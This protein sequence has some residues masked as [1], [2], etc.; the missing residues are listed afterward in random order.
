M[1]VL[2]LTYYFPPDLCAGS[3][4]AKSLVDA[5]VAHFDNVTVD[6]VTTEP[7]RYQSHQPDSAE[8]ASKSYTVTRAPLPTQRYGMLGQVRSFG[9]YAWFANRSLPSEEYDLVVATSSRLMTA[10]LGAFIARR[11]KV[12]LYL[13]IRDIFVETIDDV[14]R[15]SWMKPFRLIFSMLERWAVSRADRVNLVSRGFLPYFQSRYSRTDYRFFTNGVDEEFLAFPEKPASSSG[16]DVNGLLTVVYAGNVGD[17]QGLELILPELALRMKDRA[18]FVVIG[19]GGT[20]PKLKSACEQ[21][22]APV[23]LRGAMP[24]SE[25]LKVYQGADVLFLHL[26]NLP[27][28]TRVLPSKLFEYAATGKPILAGVQG[29][30]RN[31]IDSELEGVETFDPGDVDGAEAALNRL[32]I[33]YSDRRAF[34]EQ[35][36]RPKIMKDMAADIVDLAEQGRG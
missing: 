31:F 29:Y 7:N 11:L 32:R 30:A 17:G 26:N 36:A 14:F 19:D 10:C 22:S 9:Q 4:R 16:E 8:V 33:G 20:L 5:L 24:R 12:P 18:R 27:A 21:L 13:D 23:V 3:F 35:F 1:R 6:V 28:F 2:L 15:A 34:V 25:L